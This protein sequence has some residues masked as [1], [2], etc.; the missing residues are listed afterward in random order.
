MFKKKWLVPVIV[1]FLALGIASTALAAS[2]EPPL[3]DDPPLVRGGRLVYGTLSHLS[4][5]GFSLQTPGGAAFH[6]RVDERTHYRSSVLEAPAFEDLVVGTK[7]GVAARRLGAGPGPGTWIARLVVI[8]PDDFDPSQRFGLRVRGEVL[9]VDLDQETFSL[10]KMDGEELVFQVDANT[11]FL[12][13]ASALADL[14]TGWR[15]GVAGEEQQDGV[16]LA[17][18]VAAADPQDLPDFEIKT[19]GRVTAVTQDS[20]TIQPPQGEA[21]TFQVDE[22]T[23]IRDRRVPGSAQGPGGVGRLRVGM[24]VLSGAEE[25][26]DGESMARLV[27]ILRP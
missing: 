1:I 18:R 11:R 25:R 16:L 23:H 5:Q 14:E 2:N 7:V 8:L 12:G 22:N 21:L 4:A 6:F 9:V 24:W 26:P 20:L 19:G 13:Q 27:L 10:Q 17:R 15:V 3:Q